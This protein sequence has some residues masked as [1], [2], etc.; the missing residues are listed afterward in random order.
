MTRL[1]LPDNRAYLRP[2]LSGVREGLIHDLGPTE[3]DLLTGQKL[4]IDRAVGITGVIRLIEEHAKE[5]G[6]F[7]GKTLAPVL[8]ANYNV[9]VNNLRMIL[10]ALGLKTCASER[11]LGPL[12]LAEQVD[13]EQAERE[14]LEAERRAESPVEA[15]S[16]GDLI[17]GTDNSDDPTGGEI[18][19][20]GGEDDEPGR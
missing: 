1:T 13:Q 20:E 19:N 8:S 15:R 4:L 3:K 10:L 7:E 16:P 14:A 11:I 12:E 5:N 17:A 18:D 9:F 6:I 2:Y